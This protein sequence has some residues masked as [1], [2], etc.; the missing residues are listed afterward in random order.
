MWVEAIDGILLLLAISV[1]R[2]VAL[3]IAGLLRSRAR[4]ARTIT[5][6]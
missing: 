3:R 1:D 4:Q 5:N 2:I 6:D